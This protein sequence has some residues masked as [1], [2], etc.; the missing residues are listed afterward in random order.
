MGTGLTN[1]QQPEGAPVADEPVV[2]EASPA[3]PKKKKRKLNHEE[4]KKWIAER[5]RQKVEKE[6]K[7]LELK[8]KREKERLEKEAQKQKEKEEKDKEREQKLKEREEKLKEKE[9]KQK[10]RDLE[11]QKKQEEIMEKK[12]KLDEEK[13]R[14]EE[15]KL[16]RNEKLEKQSSI[17]KSF[18]IK[19][20]TKDKSPVN[21]QVIANGLF[22]PFHLSAN[23]TIAP[24][25]RDVAKERF[26]RKVLDELMA[27]QEC[28]RLY[29]ES[30]QSGHYKP[31]K[32]IEKEED[33]DDDIQI[34]VEDQPEDQSEDDNRNDNQ[35]K[36]FKAKY[37][38]FHENVRPAYRGT[39]RKSSSKIKPRLPFGKDDG[40]F[41]YEVDSDD[42]WEEEEPGELV[43]GSDSEGS[44]KG[45]DY[46]IDNDFFVPHGYL[47]EDENDENEEQ[48]IGSRGDVEM[49]DGS[50]EKGLKCRSLTK[51]QVLMAERNRSFSSS[52]VPI[53]IGCVWESDP[54]VNNKLIDSLLPFKMVRISA[55]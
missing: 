53:V 23:Q 44:V 1:S 37:L 19:K 35:S 4:K 52:L 38:L 24:V 36:K 40:L 14:K 8:A 3:Q 25:V 7:A 39:F 47:S 18:F 2:T 13:A 26:D 22:L 48:A 5:E 28:S 27:S 30:L 32:C 17:L 51:E 43:D 42:E 20:V 49:A 31:L 54:N 50:G 45:D 55:K 11:R 15:E 6:K 46:E 21:S 29:L 12:R 33:D 41:D 34:I 16:K 9:E 10:E